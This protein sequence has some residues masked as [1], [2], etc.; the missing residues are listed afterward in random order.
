MDA[1]SSPGSEHAD[2]KLR[3]ELCTGEGDRR[4][5]ADETPQGECPELEGERAALQP[6]RRQQRWSV[7]ILWPLDSRVNETVDVLPTCPN[8]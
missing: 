3:R 6:G 1:E 4:P 8:G 7:Y 5:S 2:V